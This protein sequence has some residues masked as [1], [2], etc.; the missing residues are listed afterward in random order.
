MKLE[1]RGG[2]QTVVGEKDIVMLKNCSVADSF[3]DDL[4]NMYALH[5]DK[6][7]VVILNDDV[8]VVICKKS[9]FRSTG[10]NR[11]PYER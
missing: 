11:C 4:R 10:L 6:P 8:E 5:P 3:Y 9:Q 2:K 7:V 1:I